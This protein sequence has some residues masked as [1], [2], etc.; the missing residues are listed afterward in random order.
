MAP[1]PGRTPRGPPDP[2]RPTGGSAWLASWREPPAPAE[3]FR[4]L[5]KRSLERGGEPQMTQELRKA[6]EWLRNVFLRT[7]ARTILCSDSAPPV[8][9]ITDGAVEEDEGYGHATPPRRHKCL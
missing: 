4:I 8:F 5:T 9:I 3:P 6:V 1:L 2:G 7:A